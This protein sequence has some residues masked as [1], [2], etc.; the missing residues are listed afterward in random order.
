VLLGGALTLTYAVNRGAF[1]GLGSS[2]PPALRFALSL[3]AN[4]VIIAWGMILILRTASIQVPRLTSV[5]LLVGGGIGN[6]IDRIGHGGAVID[7]MV[8]RVGPLH[9]GIF[10]VADLAV[11]GGA[12]VLGALAFW[13][14][15]GPEAPLRGQ[16]DKAADAPDEEKG[17]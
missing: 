1:L 11:V 15:E 3:L 12:L 4:G 5:A 17:S 6:L 8:L 10:N 13:E 9:T 16:E 2:L 14:S 7:F